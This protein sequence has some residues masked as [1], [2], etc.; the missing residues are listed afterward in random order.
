MK[1]YCKVEDCNKIYYARGYCRNHY[2]FYSRNGGLEPTMENIKLINEIKKAKI[3][4]SMRKNKVKVISPEKWENLREKGIFELTQFLTIF[5]ISIEKYSE[6][7]KQLTE[8]NEIRKL[9][10]IIKELKKDS[11]EIKQIIRKNTIS[12]EEVHLLKERFENKYVKE[13]NEKY[14]QYTL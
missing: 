9:K 10:K 12:K 2:R 4:I 1:K 5:E 13:R 3:S 6:E 8:K 14:I 11:E 7:I